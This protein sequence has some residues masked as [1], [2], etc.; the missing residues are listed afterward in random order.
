[1]GLLRLLLAL[2][3]V[4]FHAK[5]PDGQIFLSFAGAINIF[6][7]ISG[8][9]MGL[10]LDGKYKSKIVFY[11]SRLLR[12][13]PLYWTALI[14][15]LVLGLSKTLIGLGQDNPIMHYLKLSHHLVG[16]SGFFD[17][18][19]FILRNISL[20]LTKDYFGISSNLS[21]GY[22]IVNQAWTLQIELIFYLLVPFIVLIKKNLLI[23]ILAYIVIF[24]F[25]VAP[26]HAAQNDSLTYRFLEQFT[27]FL[28]GLASY[29]YIYHHI[30]NM[31]MGAKIWGLYI[32]LMLYFIFY[33]FLP[34]RLPESKAPLSLLFY[35]PLAAFI[36]FIFT[37]FKNNSLDRYIGELSYP[38]YI[39]HMIFV[40]I[41]F[42]L[43]LPKIQFLNTFLISLATIILSVILIKFVQNPIDNIRHKLGKG[44]L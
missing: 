23:M 43:N 44:K 4:S 3:V 27:F 22:L 15:T 31:K 34:F 8:F 37:L 33:F 32:L 1:M 10:I 6:F 36:P 11:K 5:E 16:I 21:Q 26:F 2:S 14:L 29:R 24:Y 35:I 9:Y 18:F 28:I 12:I 17:T 13:F 42:Q 30:K 19:N 20:I 25:L 39:L 38:V 7:I 40:K 41:V